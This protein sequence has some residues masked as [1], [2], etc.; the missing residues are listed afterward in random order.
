MH[1]AYYLD[2]DH[3]KWSVFYFARGER[4]DKRIFYKETQALAKLRD[5]LTAGPTVYKRD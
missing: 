3:Q 4:T 2:W 1:E 5:R